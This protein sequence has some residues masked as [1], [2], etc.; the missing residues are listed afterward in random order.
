MSDKT[1]TQSGS[2]VNTGYKSGITPVL[3][4]VE[5]TF[6]NCLHLLMPS[7]A[8]INTK[9]PQGE[10]LGVIIAAQNYTG[11]NHL[12]NAGAAIN[13]TDSLGNTAWMAAV[14]CSA[15]PIYNLIL[16]YGVLMYLLQQM[17]ILKSDAS[18]LYKMESNSL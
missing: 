7:V 10:T 6:N 5:K 9:S 12:L 11:M 8:N 1:I 18:E 3:L 16:K 15:I 2:D 13:M 17:K 4:A 14:G